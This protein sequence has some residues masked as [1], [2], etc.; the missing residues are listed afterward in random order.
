MPRC[1]LPG[2]VH[3]CGGKLRRRTHPLH[4]HHTTAPPLCHCQVDAFGGFHWSND[5][6]ATGLAA[7][8]PL[9]MLDAALMLPDY[10]VDPKEARTVSN[11][12]LGD[13]LTHMVGERAAA[14][15]EKMKKQASERA[16]A[17]VGEATGG[18]ATG[19][20]GST[21][22]GAT[23]GSD[24][25]VAVGA[26][27]P[28]QPAGEGAPKEKQQRPLDEPGVSYAAAASPQERMV[29]AMAAS[30]SGEGSSSGVGAGAAPP[31]GPLGAAWIRT[32]VGLELYQVGGLLLL[33]LSAPGPDLS[34]S[35]PDVLALECLCS[36]CAFAPA[37]TGA[38]ATPCIHPLPCS[39]SLRCS[40]THTPR[41]PARRP[42]TSAA[43]PRRGC[44]LWL[45]SW[46]S[47]WESSPMRCSTVQWCSHCSATGYGVWVQALLGY[48]TDKHY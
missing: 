42:S 1:C 32:R 48:Y 12:I 19:A 43:T 17:A 40:C 10:S 20:A 35:L 21:A 8:V 29:A 27:E 3:F 37:C 15:K 34:S 11:V 30:A 46:S 23:G 26:S 47:W 33:L 28:Q 18:A 7:F 4:L 2:P 44:R 25:A 31:P 6:I 38:A 24:A 16:D 39:P 22:T 14:A 9:M 41:R 5:D 13:E 36:G 45:S